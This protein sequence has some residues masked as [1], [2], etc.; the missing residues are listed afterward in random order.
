M[1]RID[2][3]SSKVTLTSHPSEK[4]EINGGIMNPISKPNKTSSI[5]N[6]EMSGK[7]LNLNSKP[8]KKSIIENKEMNGKVLKPIIKPS[9]KPIKKLSIE[10]KE[11]NGK[12]LNPIKP[13]KKSIIG[14]KEITNK[15][16]KPISRPIKK[17]II[18]NLSVEK[19][20]QL[21]KYTNYK[22]LTMKNKENQVPLVSKVP[23]EN[24]TE[25]VSK[26]SII[27]N[28]MNYS[29]E[30][31]QEDAVTQNLEDSEDKPKAR[32]R[33]KTQKKKLTEEE[34]F[35]AMPIQEITS[36]LDTIPDLEDISNLLIDQLQIL[37]CLKL[38]KLQP[39]F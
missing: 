3:N 35:N 34:A 6:K 31:K 30:L 16:L 24:N 29:A 26:E 13:A 23:I 10:N 38:L 7:N 17:S 32:G 22:P 19:I 36:I 8:V 18:E 5:E 4:K 39:K 12:N 28:I 9:S 25:S 11:M 21:E 20:N 14:N 33:P 1:F 15:I 27:N 2:H 37:R